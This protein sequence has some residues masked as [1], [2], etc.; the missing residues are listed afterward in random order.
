MPATPSSAARSRRTMSNRSAASRM[1][2]RANAEGV[3][4]EHIASQS[5]HSDL[6]A[7]RRRARVRAREAVRTLR[8]SRVTIAAGGAEC[9]VP[10]LR[11]PPSAMRRSRSSR[12][13]GLECAQRHLPVLQTHDTPPE[14]DVVD[15]ARLDRTSMYGCRAISTNPARVHPSA[16]AL[17]SVRIART[18]GISRA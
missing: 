10:R 11:S 17:N 6:S 5:T 3:A 16:A 14:A 18:A 2:V 12:V 4:G 15:D 1:R 8:G 9:R 13:S 7:A